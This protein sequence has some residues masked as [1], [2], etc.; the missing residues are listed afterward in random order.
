MGYIG[1]FFDFVRDMFSTG[2]IGVTLG[3]IIVLLLALLI[4]FILWGTFIAVDSWFLPRQQMRGVITGKRHSPSSFM[5][6]TTTV[7][8]GSGGFNTITTM[9][10][11]PESWSVSVKLAD[12][13]TGGMGVSEGYF[14]DIGHDESVTVTFVS[15]RLSRNIYVKALS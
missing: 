4:G 9:T 7:S 3:C 1:S 14:T 12:G 10:Y 13:R 2:W 15:G 6:I 8:N 5:P 11:I